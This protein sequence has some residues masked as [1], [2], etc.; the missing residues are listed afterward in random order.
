M[1]FLIAATALT[2]F[3][4]SGCQPPDMKTLNPPGID[5]PPPIPEGADESMAAGESANEV[6]VE[7]SELPENVKT[8]DLQTTKPQEIGKTEGG[9]DYTINKKGE[10]TRRAK[11]GD[12]VVV[13]YVGRLMN[14]RR[15]DSSRERNEPFRFR[16]G[17]GQVIK[18]W[19]ELVTG[20]K[21]GETRQ[22]VIPPEKAYGKE[23]RP[24]TIPPNAELIFEVELLDIR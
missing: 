4:V 15:F 12:E 5:S 20:M 1:K 16:I 21:I 9:M 18:G 3:A 24:P 19:D 10:G 2:L 6:A 14:G 7:P 23:G 22:A 11:A 17:S 8:P 13:H